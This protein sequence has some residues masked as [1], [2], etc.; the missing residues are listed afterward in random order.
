MFVPFFFVSLAN[1]SRPSQLPTSRTCHSNIL[2]ESSKHSSA[3]THPAKNSDDYDYIDD[4]Y[5]SSPSPLISDPLIKCYHRHIRDHIASLFQRHSHLT[6]NK[7]P[8]NVNTLVGEGKAM[9]VAGHKLVFVLETLHEHLRQ[10]SKIQQISTPLM[11]LTRQLCDALQAFVLLLKQL[12]Q[13]SCTKNSNL[14]SNFHQDTQ[15]IINIVKRIKRQCRV[16]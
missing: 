13:D 8:S 2:L 10:T 9:V 15:S 16:V 14:M 6:Q 7:L 1:H 5:P 3:G 4:D 11:S 12:T